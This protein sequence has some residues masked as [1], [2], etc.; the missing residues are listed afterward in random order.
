MTVYSKTLFVRLV[1][2]GSGNE[3]LLVGPDIEDVND[4]AVG[5][6][7]TLSE[8]VARYMLV[9]TGQIQRTALSY[10]EDEKP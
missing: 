8:D 9:G 7:D 10:V 2:P 3:F 5:D 1:N 6:N 4:T